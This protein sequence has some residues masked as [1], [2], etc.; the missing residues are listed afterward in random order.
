MATYSTKGLDPLVVVSYCTPV[1]IQ[2]GLYRVSYT[3]L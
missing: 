1:R 3:I 2:K